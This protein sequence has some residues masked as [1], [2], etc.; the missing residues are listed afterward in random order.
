MKR[1]KCPYCRSLF[2]P[3]PRVKD[4]QKTCGSPACQ[5]ALK[6][7]NN[8]RWREENS[9]CCRHDYPR[10]KQWLDRH[11]GYLKRY[12]ESHPEY[13]RKNREAQR[14]RDRKRKI[15]LDI[16]AKIRNQP[17]EIT[18]ELWNLSH[19]AHLDIQDEIIL[20]PLEMT[21]LFSIFPCLD[22]QI[23]F[24]KLG[25]PMDNGIIQIRGDRHANQTAS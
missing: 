17:P 15:H 19:S 3:H 21:Y 20:H 1:E 23:H 5:K 16:Q 14:L 6:A 9:D 11:P 4:R 24:D 7:Q 13:V 22:I 2:I 25:C 18:N 12:R 10:V 8:A